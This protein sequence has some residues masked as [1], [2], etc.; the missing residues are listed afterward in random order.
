MGVAGYRL[1]AAFTKYKAIASNDT[2]NNALDWIFDRL[3]EEVSWKKLPLTRPKELIALGSLNTAMISLMYEVYTDQQR[4]DLVR[5]GALST[6]PDKPPNGMSIWERI[7]TGNWE[8]DPIFKEAGIK[9]MKGKTKSEFFSR[10]I[11]K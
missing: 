5:L 9:R 6:I 7:L 2:H 10:F 3:T 8:S 11:K 1:P 4:A